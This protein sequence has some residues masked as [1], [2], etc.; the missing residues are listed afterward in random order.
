MID[1][2]FPSTISGDRTEREALRGRWR[3]E[4][5]FTKYALAG[6]AGER[7]SQALCPHKV[8]F[9]RDTGDLKAMTM[10]YSNMS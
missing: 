2:R 6:D 8:V 9:N 7:G 5:S 3:A 10:K 4:D 1:L